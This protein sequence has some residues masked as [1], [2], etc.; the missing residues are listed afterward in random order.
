MAPLDIS[1]IAA[2]AKA[3]AKKDHPT[4]VRN[5]DIAERVKAGE[6]F[7][8]IGRSY[9]ISRERVRQIAGTYDVKSSHG[10]RMKA[11]RDEALKRRADAAALIALTVY[12]LKI[13]VEENGLSIAAGVKL[14][15]CRGLAWRLAKKYGVRSPYKSGNP[16]NRIDR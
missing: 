12:H 5:Q 10:L 14:G 9:G 13:E 6:L 11:Y 3:D 4:L 1:I 16:N 7:S 8:D 2:K 15:I